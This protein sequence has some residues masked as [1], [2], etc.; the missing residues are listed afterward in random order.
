V[1][2]IGMSAHA[3]KRGN[4][5]GIRIHGCGNAVL[6]L[7]AR[8]N[9]ADLGVFDLQLTSLSLGYYCRAIIALRDP[10]GQFQ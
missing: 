3:I 7:A 10:H 9:Q 1:R 4:E 2:T 5:R 8:S 6:V